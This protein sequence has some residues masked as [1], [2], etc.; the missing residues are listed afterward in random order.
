VKFSNLETQNKILIISFVVFLLL[1]LLLTYRQNPRETAQDPAA[2]IETADT[3]IPAGHVL[4]PIEIENVESVSGIIGAFAL[5]DLYTRA[6]QAD[7]AEMFLVGQK[8]KLIRAPLNPNQYAVLVT[9]QQSTELLKMNPRFWVTIHNQKKSLEKQDEVRLPNRSASTLNL[10][11][12]SGQI[13]LEKSVAT[14]T[15]ISS[16]NS[17]AAAS[18]ASATTLVSNSN[19][20]L[21]KNSKLKFK[22]EVSDLKSSKRQ[23]NTVQDANSDEL[24]A[25]SKKKRAKVNDEILIE[26]YESK[27]GHYL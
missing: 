13:A 17:S 25:Q 16:S 20:I 6:E 18:A 3:Y 23:K 12:N 24:R 14:S 21:N 8:I 5:V 27:K 15:L 26:Y 1:Y 9:E 2:K 7:T 4:V 22:S 19:T 11:T 10:P